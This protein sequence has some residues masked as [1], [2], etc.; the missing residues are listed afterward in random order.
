M[1]LSLGG[2]SFA[3]S[4]TAFK[5]N[6]NNV[7]HKWTK[8]VT[9]SGAVYVPAEEMSAVLEQTYFY[10]AD[11]KTHV[12]YNHDMTFGME[13]KSGN[14]KVISYPIVLSEDQNTTSQGASKTLNMSFASKVIGSDLYVP[15]DYYKYLGIKISIDNKNKIAKLT[16]SYKTPLASKKYTYET[17]MLKETASNS[18][19][20]K[21][22][23]DIEKSL[24]STKSELAKVEKAYGLL[25]NDNKPVS[26]IAEVVSDEGDY[27]IV[28]GSSFGFTYDAY[29]GGY[30]KILSPDRTAISL[31]VYTGINFYS[32][33]ENDKVY[34]KLEV[35]DN[36]SEE[37]ATAKEKITKLKQTIAVLENNLAALMEKNNGVTEI[38]Y[39]N[40]DYYKGTVNSSGQPN[41]KG[42][43]V[44]ANGDTYEGDW[45]N[46]QRTG[47]GKYTF[48]DGDSYEGE[49]LKDEFHGKG[50]YKM[51][52]H[53]AG[54][55]L[56]TYVP[57]YFSDVYV[58]EFSN[59]KYNGIGMLKHTPNPLEYSV[60]A[61]KP[62]VY[63]GEF[64]DDKFNGQGSLL[65]FD[66]NVLFEGQWIMGE[67]VMK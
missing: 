55:L 66:G 48:N 67:P 54:N 5:I 40:G 2:T 50:T 32:H 38:K 59:G 47:S 25:I 24:S 51:G 14:K 44:W 26:I 61:D 9:T 37:I 36:G 19:V 41:G 34:G 15:L 8:P 29:S 35:Y 16:T 20:T 1:V 49:F 28:R 42:S 10:D 3:S 60:G 4:S 65:D 30:K 58:G 57:E 56:G 23:A 52:Y 45:V 63:N 33:A 21:Q 22:I 53:K 27:I 39:D 64:K 43:I 46:N 13:V 62:F 11:Y 7:E 12:F 31:G 18:D 6:I 17:A